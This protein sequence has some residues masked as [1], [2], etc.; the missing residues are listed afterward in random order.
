MP[1][2]VKGGIEANIHKRGNCRKLLWKEGEVLVFEQVQDCPGQSS[3]HGKS[4]G[5]HL[6]SGLRYM[7]AIGKLWGRAS[8]YQGA[9]HKALREQIL[10][11]DP[12]MVSLWDVQEKRINEPTCD[13]ERHTWK[14]ISGWGDGIE[15]RRGP[16]LSE[17]ECHQ[18]AEKKTA[19]DM[20]GHR[21]LFLLW[22]QF[23]TI[24]PI[25]WQVG[26]IST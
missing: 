15:K 9:G 14:D 1:F 5:W 6:S 22:S 23:I 19:L 16:D 11:W 20:P 26:T 2:L 17:P 4:Q 18:Q 21:Y 25:Q 12:G 13:G 3:P 24:I 8:G 10:W 7:T